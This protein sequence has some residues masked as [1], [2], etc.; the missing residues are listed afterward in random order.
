MGDLTFRYKKKEERV[1]ATYWRRRFF[2]LVVGL[3][4][5][6]V[7]A[8]SVSGAIGGPKAIRPAANEITGHQHHHAGKGPLSGRPRPATAAHQSTGPSPQPSGSAGNSPGG[9]HQRAASPHQA[10]K[11]RRSPRQARTGQK[12]PA[13][14]TRPARHGGGSAYGRPRACARRSVVISLFA[15]QVSYPAHARPVFDLDVVS[16]E[17]R[18]CTFNVG[19]RYLALVI[20]AGKNRVWSSADCLQGRKSLFTDL[21]KGVP[22]ALSISWDRRTSAPGCKLGSSPVPTG[23]YVA[24]AVSGTLTSNKEIFRLR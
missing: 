16:T 17:G 4:I 11:A 7:L 21:V 20:K 18:T 14:A 13:G 22:T 9:H 3:A 15:S 8:W 19:A 10:R 12:Q 2:A 1:A 24:T 23:I 6:A 5:F